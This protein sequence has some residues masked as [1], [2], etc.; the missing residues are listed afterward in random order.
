MQ[1][2]ANVL[3]TLLH[4]WRNLILARGQLPSHCIWADILVGKRNYFILRANTCASESLLFTLRFLHLPCITTISA[5][6]TSF[7][8]GCMRDTPPK[9]VKGEEVYFWN[10]KGIIKNGGHS[11]VRFCLCLKLT[12]LSKDI[13]KIRWRCKTLE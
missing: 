11:E 10:H 6:R 12:V 3:E 2:L 4:S 1:L 8:C 9:T 13:S 7:S 5:T